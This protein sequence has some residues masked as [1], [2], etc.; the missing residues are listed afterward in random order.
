MVDSRTPAHI[1]SLPLLK[2]KLH[3]FGKSRRFESSRP[4]VPNVYGYERCWVSSLYTERERPSGSSG[5]S[6]D[7]DAAVRTPHQLYWMATMKINN[8]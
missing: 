6:A 5:R 4:A 3:S 2:L 7:S 1:L 8:P